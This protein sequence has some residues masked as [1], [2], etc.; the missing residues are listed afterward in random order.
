[1]HVWEHTC[2]YVG[3]YTYVHVEDIN[4]PLDFIFD[5]SSPYKLWQ[6]I[7]LETRGCRFR[8]PCLLTPEYMDLATWKP[9]KLLQGAE[10]PKYGQSP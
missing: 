7:S 9:T 4:E 8:I 6:N 2:V 10:D 5:L 1:M 3:V